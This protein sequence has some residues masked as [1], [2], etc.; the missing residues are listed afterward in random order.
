MTLEGAQSTRNKRERGYR[1]HFVLNSCPSPNHPPAFDTKAGGFRIPRWHEKPL[2]IGLSGFIS[3]NDKCFYHLHHT[4]TGA[5]SD[6]AILHLFFFTPI[7][8]YK[9]L[10]QTILI[11]QKY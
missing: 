6:D 10:R 2:Q 3:P 8:V 11:T 9:A 1:V 5:G 4:Q 7:Y